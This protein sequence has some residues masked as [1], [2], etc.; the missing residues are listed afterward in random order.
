[1]NYRITKGKIVICV[2]GI[3]LPITE[4]QIL[5][6]QQLINEIKSGDKTR[7]KEDAR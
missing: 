5:D 3:Y 2:N 4:A 7:Y 6:F 1:M